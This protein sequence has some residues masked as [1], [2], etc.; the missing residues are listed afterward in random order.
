MT[1]AKGLKGLLGKGLT[2]QL[3]KDPMMALKGRHGVYGLMIEGYY[4]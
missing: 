4:Y 3:F 1:I 2:V